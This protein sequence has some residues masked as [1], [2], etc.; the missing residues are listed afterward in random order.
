LSIL[1][2]RKNIAVSAYP[3][4]EDQQRE[5]KTYR[6]K[7]VLITYGAITVFCIIF[8]FIYAQF[9]HGVDSV[10]MTFMFLFPLVGCVGLFGLAAL[11][12]S[13]TL[14][15]FSFNAY[16]SGIATLLTGS[17][18]RGICEIAGT[19]SFY[20]DVFFVVGA[21]FVVVGIVYAIAGKK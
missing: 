7:G 9:S 12:G 14:P 19:A 3:V 21:G 6:R 20:Q 4:G 2:K 18:L 17:L 10:W 1:D 15:R 16:N 8:N 11:L 13:K 5:R